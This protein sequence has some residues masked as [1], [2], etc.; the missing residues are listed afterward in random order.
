L[1]K[2]LRNRTDCR[3][4]P[5]K[6]AS[7]IRQ[8]NQK[9]FFENQHRATPGVAPRGVAFL[10][11]ENMTKQTQLKKSLTKEEVITELKQ[12]A[13]KL[14]RVPTY[15]ELR[16]MSRVTVNGIRKHFGTLSLALRTA[17]LEVGHAGITSS[18]KDLFNDWAGV[19][20]AVKRVPTVNDY[21]MHGKYSPRPL[22]TRFG[23]WSRVAE[24]LREFA[25]RE[26]LD[27]VHPEL[28]AM[29]SAWKLRRPP[30]R[31]IV[32]RDE[33]G[34]PLTH[35]PRLLLD[36]P[37]YGRPLTPPGLAHELVN[38]MGVVY[39]FGLLGHRLG[40]VVTRI[41]SEFPDCEAFREVEPGRWQRVRI[42]FEFESR[43]FL[44][45]KHDPKE[46]DVIVCWK[47]NWADC[48]ANIEVIELSSM[49]KRL[50]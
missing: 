17:E 28:M 1:G 30:T 9:Q 36:R 33:E 37:V 43:N 15:P 22:L 32:L 44:L 8:L 39:L 4:F 20:R 3:A 6:Q 21:H 49:M 2:D 40:Y 18:M 24:G 41:Q 27:K 29:I 25:E 10:F 34:V 16:K 13:K 7:S 45:H 50:M 42:E 12:C 35:K 5:R 11:E 26:G 19:A 31:T 46:C 47:H 38:E 14:G 48:P 23:V